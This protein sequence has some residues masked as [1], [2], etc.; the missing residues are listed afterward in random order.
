MG[1]ALCVT[2]PLYHLRVKHDTFTPVLNCK[3]DLPPKTKV[4]AELII[5]AHAASRTSHSPSLS[6]G[7][8]SAACASSSDAELLIAAHA[9]L[10]TR[11]W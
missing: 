8:I 4:D 10:R 7:T 5:A 6:S 9:A 3:L 1:A 2:V 11:S